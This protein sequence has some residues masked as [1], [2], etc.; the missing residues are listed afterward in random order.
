MRRLILLFGRKKSEPPCV[1]GYEIFDALLLCFTRTALCVTRTVLGF[2]GASYKRP[3]KSKSSELI[4]VLSLV[5]ALWF[6]QVQP[7][8]AASH[9]WSGAVSGNWSVAGNWSA[10]GVPTLAETNSITLPATATRYVMTNNIGALKISAF[11]ISGTNYIVRGAST[12][13]IQSSLINFLCSGGSNTIESAMT[14]AGI[15]SF[16][17]NGNS[18]LVLSGMLSGTNGF[19][20]NGTGDMYLR[21]AASNPLSGDAFVYYGKLHLQKS[22]GASPFNI[23]SLTIGNSVVGGIPDI[24]YV[25]LD[26]ADQIPDG[27]AINFN[28]FG[29]LKMNGYSDIVGAVTMYSGI[30]DA[31]S[32]KLFLAGD[33]T[34]TPRIVGTNELGQITYESPTLW[35]TI[36]FNGTSRN[37]NVTTNTA[38]IDAVIVETGPVTA[39]NKTGPG[40]LKLTAANSFTGALNI[41]AG[42]VIADNSSSLGTVAGG[43]T[44]SNGCTLQIS[45]GVNS[46]EALS[47]TGLGNDGQGALQSTGTATMSGGITLTGDTGIS[48]VSSNTLNLD[49]VIS[50]SGGIR[51]FGDGSLRLNGFGNNS[52]SSA[53][54]VTK[55][56]LI[57]SKGA[58]VRAIGSVAVTN[59][60]ELT[61]FQNEQIDNAGVVTIYTGGLFN[62]T[63]HNES[64]GGLN[65]GGGTVVDTG[66]GTLTMFGNFY[67]GT[68]YSATNKPA[69]I[70]GNLSLGGATRIVTSNNFNTALVFDCAISD[71]VG[72][73][74]LQA[75]QVFFSLLRSNSFTGPVLL[76][77]AY[78]SI[79]NS[80]SFGASGGGVISTNTDYSSGI[81]F[82]DPTMVV[83]G[84]TLT[85]GNSLFVRPK[86]SNA[87][88]NPIVLTNGGQLLCDALSLPTTTLTVNGKISGNGNIFADSGTLRL[89][90][91][92]DYSGFSA[93]DIGGTLAITHPHSL[94]T[95]NQ[96]TTIYEGGNLRLELPIGTAV[97]GE[98]LFFEDTGFPTTNAWLTMADVG[99][100]NWKTNT[101]SG[102]I[103]MNG[104][105]RISVIPNDGIFRLNSVITGTGSLAKTGPGSLILCGNGTNQLSNLTVEYGPMYLAQT[106]GY[107]VSSGDVVVNGTAYMTFEGINYYRPA[108]VELSRPGQL[109]PFT[110]LNL[111]GP[112]GGFGVGEQSQTIRQLSGSGSLYGGWDA[113]MGTLILSNSILDTSLFT[114]PIYILGNNTN[115]IKQGGGDLMLYGPSIPYSDGSDVIDSIHLNGSVLIQ[116]GGLFLSNG[117]IGKL[118]IADF[119]YAQIHSAPTAGVSNY[120]QNGLTI[121]SLT[122]SGNVGLYDGARV[123]V[124]G[125]SNNATFSGPIYGS[126]PAKIVKTGANAQTLTGAGD[127]FTGDTLVENGTLVVNG[128]LGGALRVEPAMPGYLPTLSG[129]G[130]LG[131]VVVTGTGARI[132]PG[133][134]TNVPSYGKLTV[135]NIAL[136]ANALY[137]CEIGG[138]NAGVNLD[139]I[140]AKDTTTLLNGAAS[141]TAFGAGVISNRYAVVKSAAAVNGAFTGDPEGDTIVPAAGRSMKITYLTAGGK[142]V[143]LIDQ[144]SGPFG[145][146]HIGGISRGTNGNMTITGTGDIG[147]TY[148]IEAN[149]DLN[150]TNWVNLGSVLGDWNGGISFTDTNAPNFLQRFYRFKQQ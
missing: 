63:N 140:E 36:E 96:G 9:T 137:L 139:Q 86:G 52:F 69:T 119:T 43:T 106:N 131:N 7:A 21:G 88:N 17:I 76:N 56:Q 25:Y 82:L 115:L 95:T 93:V 15:G 102:P 39:L 135:N 100:P 51:K 103:T 143:T 67:V 80:F 16:S 6:V 101:W 117:V 5:A 11:T 108:Y 74:G 104:L 94:G 145:T 24:A 47:I 4:R 127:L 107:A 58:N 50:G 71:G 34:L 19:I 116:G 147:A 146:I 41:N 110:T 23:S 133:A 124:G 120:V 141:F 130:T 77:S 13:S 92:N 79:S 122:G 18:T 132:A 83:S 66:A 3:M 125:N 20:K 111:V 81:T 62:M 31:T 113:G 10:G 70:Q 114:G 65:L 22:G 12:F 90:Q 40:T 72:T 134:T 73:G 112:E 84:E 128:S 121:R 105:A 59:G 26:A 53:S 14:F 46:S 149:G 61:L 57:L 118:D 2:M 38:N 89:T 44:V 48:V 32:G 129:I 142:E 42:R 64:I 150:T 138:T 97:T 144:L 54:F 33:L 91:S 126:Y 45:S 49:G 136:D 78:C 60:A 68:P 123:Y 30:V 109:P 27:A 87:W 1:G 8:N 35:G 148:F 55:G 29:A 28:V 37:I 99:G 98:S 75:D 85:L